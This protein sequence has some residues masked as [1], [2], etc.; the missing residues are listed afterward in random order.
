MKIVTYPDGRS[1]QIGTPLELAQFMFNLTAYQTMQKFQ[2]LV[3]AL[4][5]K[6]EVAKSV[7]VTTPE[8]S[9][10]KRTSKR[11]QGESNAD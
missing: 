3:D 11:K 9:R 5:T 1:E 10:K 6:T 2:K 4:P 7:T 8:I